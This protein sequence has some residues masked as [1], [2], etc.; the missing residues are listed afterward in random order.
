MQANMIR[1]VAESNPDELITKTSV[2]ILYKRLFT[3]IWQHRLPLIAGLST[4]IGLSFLQALIPQITRYTID[5]LIPQQK[6]YQL[7]WVGLAIIG[8]AL[9]L[10]TL[11]YARSY[12]MALVGQKTIYNIRYTL[13][14]HLQKLSLSYYENNRTGAIMARVTQDVDSLQNLIISDVAEIIADTF[15]FVVVVSYLLY[16]DWQLTCM[17]LATLPLMVYLSQLFGTQMRGAYRDV[18]R[19]G[20]EINNH[21]QETL[22]NIKVIKACANEGYEVDRFSERNRENMEANLR[23]VQLWSVFSPVVDLMNHLGLAIVM[24]YGSWE[25]MQHQLSIGELAAFVAYLNIVNQPAKKF[26]RLLNVIQKAA[27]A[28][29]RIFATLDTEPEVIEKPEAIALPIIQGHFCFENITFGYHTNEPVLKDFNLEIPAGKTLALVGSSGAGKSTIANL[30]ARFYDPQAG[31]ITVDGYDLRDVTLKSLRSQLGIVSQETLLLHG[32]I[33]ENIA[34]GKP[35]VT[36]AEIIAAA[37]VA[38][39]HEFILEFPQGYETMIGER[40]VKLSGGQRQ[41]L[42]IARALVKNPR[43]LILDEA[44]SALDTESEALIQDALK[45]LLQGRTSLVIAHRLTTI[46]TADK[47]VVLEKGAI[48]EIGT[49]AELLTNRGRYAY[50]QSLMFKDTVELNNY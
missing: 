36:E 2:F 29:E 14:E 12:T 32:T 18:Q 27:T 45:A 41:R 47:I 4:I 1:K 5:I 3:Y 35:G 40:G 26:S 39:A 50:L 15:A 21:L 6:F 33:R 13:Y 20:A 37:Q 31:R 34:Y 24:V 25:V 22:S 10:G 49:H 48:A 30:A 44:T 46:Q 7:P 8:I 38:H 19:R 16:A 11:N 23:V 42:A 17:V 43:F 28:C 9:L